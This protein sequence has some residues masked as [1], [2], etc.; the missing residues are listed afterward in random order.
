MFEKL[1]IY[2][3]LHRLPEDVAAYSIRQWNE[4][5]IVVNS[6]MSISE[7]AE[8]RAAMEHE[9]KIQPKK[10]RNTLIRIDGELQ[11]NVKELHRYIE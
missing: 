3:S 4:A 10:T 7:Q 9:I 8:A 2:N 1:T 6:S 5:I 11:R